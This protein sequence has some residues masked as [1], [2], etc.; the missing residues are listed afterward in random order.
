MGV[1]GDGLSSTKGVG[2]GEMGGVDCTCGASE[3]GGLRNL[4]LLYI[5]DPPTPQQP[6][7]GALGVMVR[8]I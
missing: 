5:E 3:R 6:T 1:D 2:K 8:R 4:H 7:I